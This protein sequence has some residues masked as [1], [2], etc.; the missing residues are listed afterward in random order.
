MIRMADPMILLL[1]FGMGIL[2]GWL[3]KDH[4]ASKARKVTRRSRQRVAF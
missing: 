2:L 4:F 1:V 3:A